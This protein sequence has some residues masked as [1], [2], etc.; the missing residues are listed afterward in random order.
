M[1]AQLVQRNLAERGLDWT[2]YSAVFDDVDQNVSFL[3]YSLT[4]KITGYQTYRWWSTDKKSNDPKSGR[5][6]TYTI[7][8]ED[9]IFGFERCDR[10]T[11]PIFVVE[12]IFKAAKLHACGENAIAVLTSD[13]K[14]LRPLFRILRATRPVIGI[15][16]N[17]PAGERLVRRVGRGRTSPVDLDEMTDEDVHLF[18]Q[19]LL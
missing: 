17:D 8:G 14:R 15:G 11:R 18:V 12:G 5:Y 9:G 19:E 10:S 13:P 2:K 6:Y 3:L 4:G 7:K 1:T 16:D